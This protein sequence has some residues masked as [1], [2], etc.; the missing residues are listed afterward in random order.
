LK[1]IFIYSFKKLDEIDKLILVKKVK[2]Q[3]LESKFALI[4]DSVDKSQSQVLFI[5]NE[6]PNNR[7]VSRYYTICY[8]NKIGNCK[9]V[10]RMV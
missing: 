8:R 2:A 9:K 10:S 3:E 6:Y 7:Y 4:C 5:S 1:S